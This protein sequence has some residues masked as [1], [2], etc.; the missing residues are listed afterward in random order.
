MTITHSCFDDKIFE[1][2]YKTVHAHNVTSPLYLLFQLSFL[3]KFASMAQN[4]G[5]PRRAGPSG[6]FGKMTHLFFPHNISRTS[7]KMTTVLCPEQTCLP[8]AE[9]YMVRNNKTV[10]T[11]HHRHDLRAH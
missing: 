8:I 10:I 1:Q 2:R 11:T 9:Q 4:I 6:P 7:N 3:I 5:A